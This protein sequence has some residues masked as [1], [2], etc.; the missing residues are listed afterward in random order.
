MKF[1]TENKA[2]NWAKANGYKVIVVEYVNGGA[3]L[4]VL[5]KQ[6]KG[7]ATLRIDDLKSDQ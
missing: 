1:T 7:M 2:R 4:N 3:R 6:D 5:H